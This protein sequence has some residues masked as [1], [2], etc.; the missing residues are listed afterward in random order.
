MK[1]HMNLEQNRFNMIE[2]QIRPWNVL[3]PEV[4]KLLSELRREEFVPEVFRPMAF[5][6][7]EIPLGHGEAMLTPK[8]EARILQELMVKKTDT[9]LEVGTGSGYL[10]ALLASQGA[11]VYSVE[12]QPEFRQMAEKNLVTHGFDHSRV[13]LETGDAING[14]SRYAPYDVI[15][16]T[17]SVPV[18]PEIFQES[19][20]PGGRLF[21]VVGEAPVMQAIRVTRRMAGG[22][23]TETLFETCIT[24]LRNATQPERFVF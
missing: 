19:L 14:W 7:M 21:A 1:L 15:V 12:I 5:V 10:T 9:I 2:Q 13:T 23:D 17:G 6:D 16:L 3:D 24:I 18:L 20:K 22:F 4:L 11:H 8:M